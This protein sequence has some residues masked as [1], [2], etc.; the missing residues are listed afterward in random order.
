MHEKS[1]TGNSFVLL[2]GMDRIQ[3][4]YGNFGID[5]SFQQVTA[6]LNRAQR[7]KKFQVKLFEIRRKSISQTKMEII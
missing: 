3:E 1:N 5:F 7:M 4:E 2:G 6:L